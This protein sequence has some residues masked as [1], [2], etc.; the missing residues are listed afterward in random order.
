[1]TTDRVLSA[2]QSLISPDEVQRMASEP[3]ASVW[4]G[5]SAGTGKTKVLTDRLLRLLLP[6]QDGTPG[7][8]P[9]RILCLTFTKAAASEMTIRL[10]ETLGRWAVMPVDDADGG[11]CLREILERLNGYAPTAQQ[12]K[13]AQQLFARILDAPAGLRILTIHSFCQS[14]LGRF[15]LEADLQP[16]FRVLE[17]TQ[18]RELIEQAQRAAIAEAGRLEMAGSALRNALENLTAEQSEDQFAELANDICKERGQMAGLLRGFQDVEAIYAAVCGFYGVTLGEDEKGYLAAA[19]NPAPEDEAAIKRVALAMLEGGK[20][21]QE[22]GGVILDWFSMNSQERHLN[23]WNYSR[24]FLTKAGTL[25]AKDFPSKAVRAQHPDAEDI[26]HAE[27]RRLEGILDRSKAIHSAR[28]TRDVLI[29]GEAINRKYQSLKAERGGVDYDDLILKTHDLLRGRT[30]T[31]RGLGEGREQDVTR[32]IMYKL[33]QGIDHVLVDEAQ[34]TNPEQWAIIEALCDDFF[35]GQGAKEDRVRTVFAVGDMKQSIYSFQRAAPEEFSRMNGLFHEKAEQAAQIFQNVFLSMSFRSTEAVL[36]A[37]DKTFDRD[38]LRT[39]MGG[40]FVHH[41][42]VRAGQGGL[43]EMWPIIET[44]KPDQRSFWD[45]PVSVHEGRKSVLVLADTVA[46]RIEGWL[47]SGEILPAYGRAVTPGDIMVL[48]RSRTAL[49]DALIRALKTRGVPVSGMDRMDLS[50]QLVVQDLMAAA[51]FCL[52]PPDDLTLACL[53]K[54]PL[55]GWGDA[56]LF[57]LAAGRTGDLWSALVHF[58]PQANRRLLD[59]PI[60]LLPAQAQ[61]ITAYL[62]GLRSYAQ[63]LGAY[64]FFS[65]ILLS[66]CPGDE[67]SGLRA[68]RRRLGEDSLDPLE[69][70]LRMALTFGRDQ[71]DVLELFV[72]YFESNPAEIKREMEEAGGQVRIMTVHGSKGLQAPIVILPDAIPQKAGRKNSGLLWPDKTG[73]DFPLWSPRGDDEPEAYSAVRGRLEEKAAQEDARL[74]YVA[75]TRA[76]DR[77]YVCGRKGAKGDNAYSVSWYKTIRDGLLQVPGCAEL[78][79]GRLRYETKQTAPPDKMKVAAAR[80]LEIPAL[81]AWGLAPAP[82]DAVPPRPLTPSRQLAGDEGGG[83]DITAL[84][85]LAGGTQYRFL[86][87][88]LTHKLLQFLPQFPVEHRGAAAAQF[89]DRNGGGLPGEIRPSVVREVL[90]VLDH[91]EYRAFFVPEGLAEVPVAALLEDNL[92]LSGQIDRLVVGPDHVWVLDYKTNR[93]PPERAEDVARVYLRQMR[94]Y[95]DAVTRIYP[96]RAVTCALLWTDGPRL[97]ILPE[98]ILN[99]G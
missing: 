68:L 97:M 61:A 17:E 96:G 46:D 10:F 52:L 43:V 41:T 11:P 7:T 54:S 20:N 64:E 89:M 78:A 85:P 75:M 12:I 69:E 55:I 3:A 39:A 1:M 98:S 25:Y 81:P 33:D 91:P 14:I 65:H 15:P 87:G 83:A 62:R 18:A 92:A 30:L 49:V 48:V 86:R 72:Q 27:G 26:L 58:E 60:G 36:A 29:L 71:P 9:H 99:R 88:N 38:D 40:E 95:R 44:E 2:P 51:K 21:D 19:M 73:L 23:F 37:V 8:E 32:W 70:F 63:S 31:L 42:S 66:P 22:R 34:D 45:P 77:L 67:Q 74:L 57:A 28:L 53:L 5:A 35:T 24:G 93:P 76:A 6:Q 16:H 56:E 47:R 79:D 13:A 82:E 84:S 94:A 59:D 4:V 90:A 50:P 80:A